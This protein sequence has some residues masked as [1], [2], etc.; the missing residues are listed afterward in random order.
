MISKIPSKEIF[1]RNPLLGVITLIYLIMVFP[2]VFVSFLS[3]EF[4]FI[5]YSSIILSRVFGD[6]IWEE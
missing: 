6:L 4:D 2:S 1:K 5:I 3:F